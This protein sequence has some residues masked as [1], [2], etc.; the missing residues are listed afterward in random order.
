MPQTGVERR[1]LAAPRGAGD[2]DRATGFEECV[3]DL[4]GY[5]GRIAQFVERRELLVVTK[6][7]QHATLAVEGGEGAH[8]NLAAVVGALDAAL[9]RH[10][11]LVG[12][13]PRHHLEAGDDRGVCPQR[14]VSECLEDAVIT[15][16][17]FDAQSRRLHVNVA[18]ADGVGEVEKRVHKLGCVGVLR[19]AEPAQP[20]QDVLPLQYQ[21]DGPGGVWARGDSPRPGTSPRPGRAHGRGHTIP[22]GFSCGWLQLRLAKDP[23][24]GTQAVTQ[25]PV[26][27]CPPRYFGQQRDSG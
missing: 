24:Y 21:V 17:H 5:G 22:P 10:I 25:S 7:P 9:L 19:R 8:P 14:K 18:G 20:R 16:L 6:E 13:Q 3:A 12:Q 15:E 27:T 11:G 26:E 4:A 2:Q 1:R 23:C